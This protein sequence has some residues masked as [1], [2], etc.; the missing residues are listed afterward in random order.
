MKQDDDEAWR[1]PRLTPECG[2]AGL[3]ITHRTTPTTPVRSRV[4]AIR[5]R[6]TYKEPR[7]RRLSCHSLEIDVVKRSGCSSAGAL[8]SFTS[9]CG[10]QAMNSGRSRSPYACESVNRYA[11]ILLLLHTIYGDS[12]HK[13]TLGL[14]A[15]HK[16]PSATVQ[17]REPDRGLPFSVRR[18][19]HKAR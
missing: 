12:V 11:R 17:G 5:A 18:Q 15:V 19:G 4:S 1:E 13:K 14:G 6:P 10:S 8:R 7:G 2:V 3:R 16:G 9:G